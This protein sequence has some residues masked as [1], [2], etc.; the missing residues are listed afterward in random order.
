MP[1]PQ[2]HFRIWGLPSPCGRVLRIPESCPVVAI[3]TY[4][5]TRIGAL[6][7]APLCPARVTAVS[8][9]GLPSAC[10]AEE[11]QVI[12][13]RVDP[14]LWFDYEGEAVELRLL[15]Y[16]IDGGVHALE[17]RLEDAF[18]KIELGR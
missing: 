5:S 1:L 3:K 14:Y 12:S 4:P 13:I 9:A 15:D 17:V 2:E 11:W 7:K 18:T 10:G 16:G 8:L 6:K